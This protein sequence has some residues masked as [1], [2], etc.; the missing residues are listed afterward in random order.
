MTRQSR[1]LE[2]LKQAMAL[3]DGPVAS[4]FADL[5]LVHNCLPETDGSAVSLATECAGFR[6]PHPLMINAMTGGAADLSQVNARLAEVARQTN[7]VLA[8]GSQYAAIEFPEAAESFAVVRRVNPDGVIWA[9]IGAYAD[10]ATAVRVV[11]MIRADALQ[12]HLNAAQEVS[13]REG[14]SD[15]TGWLR[16]IE[17]LARQLT[18]PVIVKETG[19]GMAREQVRLLVEAGVR[20]VD[21]GG[22][23]GTNFVAI[24]SARQNSSVA[25]IFLDWGIPAAASALEAVEELPPAVD[26][27]VSGGV[28]SPLDALKSLAI[29]AKAVAI[30]APILR[31][32]E[33]DG[34]AA[35]VQWIGQYLQGLKKGLLMLG[36]KSPRE[37][38]DQP[39]VIMGLTAQW[40]TARGISP[41]K[42]GSRP[43]RK[44]IGT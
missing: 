17:M 41:A 18:V 12:V 34:A 5:K 2:H 8:V 6:L 32:S 30:A 24:E 25:E 9:N 10:V 1:K 13:M 27:I 4:G 19:C 21:V 26:M 37:L 35:A 23:G 33:G 3:P 11:D 38:T 15:Y 28:R 44:E 42:Y 43:G 7:S 39:L 36:C 31:I 29:G 16:R 20:A 40:L 22:A 14:D